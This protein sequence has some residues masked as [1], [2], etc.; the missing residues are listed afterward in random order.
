MPLILKNRAFSNLAATLGAADTEAVI[1][2]A[3]VDRFPVLLPGDFWRGVL[4]TATGEL[5]FIR[6]TARDGASLTLERAQ[7]GSAAREFPAGSIIQCRMTALGWQ[8]LAQRTWTRVLDAGGENLI[9]TMVDAASF[10][11]PGDFTGAFEEGRAVYL[12]QNAP[13]A[14]FVAGAAHDSGTGLTTVAVS[15][16]AVDAGLVSLDLG[17]SAAVSPALT[18]VANLP[19][20]AITA[21]QDPGHLRGLT[22]R[23]TVAG[24]AFIDHGRVVINGVLHTLVAEVSLSLTGLAAD[25][26]VH[27]YVEASGGGTALA[28]GQFSA[29]DQEPARDL[30][31]GG[32]WYDPTGLKRCVGVFRTDGDGNVLPCT[33]DGLDFH[34]ADALTVLDTASPAAAAAGLA[35]GAPAAF[36]DHLLV[37]L[38]GAVTLA[39]IA[40][41]ALWV[42]PG[43]GALPLGLCNQNSAGNGGVGRG[44]YCTNTAGQVNY[45]ATENASVY[46]ALWGFRLPRGVAR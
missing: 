27:L 22:Y 26:W 44:R 45:L 4:I 29:S 42:G 14:G 8:E 13:A 41:A 33:C 32:G 20:S 39:G 6:C 21:A 16:A 17:L 9:P 25:S 35:V 5:E 24:A 30:D 37:D 3:H 19:I 15:G 1:N 43:D 31:K 11:V 36:Q 18:S 2:A 46:L 10:T 34:L 23:C 38:H 40:M 7:E 12:N 28:A